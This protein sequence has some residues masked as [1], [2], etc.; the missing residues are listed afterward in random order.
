MK[1]VLLIISLLFFMQGCQKSPKPYPEIGLLPKEKMNSISLFKQDLFISDALYE[2]AIFEVR[3]EV[4]NRKIGEPKGT[5]MGSMYNYKRFKAP[6]IEY[7]FDKPYRVQRLYLND[8]SVE[9]MRM[10]FFRKFALYLGPI[11]GIK[12][13]RKK[14]ELVS[15]DL[16]DSAYDVLDSKMSKKFT[17]M[18][19]SVYKGTK[20][21]IRLE[22][23]DTNITAL[24]F[25]EKYL[26]DLI[27]EN[28]RERDDLILNEA[29]LQ[30]VARKYAEV[31]IRLHA[32]TAE[33]K[34]PKGSISV[35][36][37]DADMSTINMKDVYE[38]GRYKSKAGSYKVF[39]P[40]EPLEV[41]LSIEEYERHIIET[42]RTIRGIKEAKDIPDHDGFIDFSKEL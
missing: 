12:K 26:F 41:D 29:L 6:I 36:P 35:L 20:E 5:D 40:D 13:N 32:H 3:P 31:Y 34:L 8:P 38:K 1:Q 10:V 16:E 27:D 15:I 39:I 19:S 2:K 30:R 21:S 4:S 28:L 24:V 7:E 18:I 23:V 17:L 14:L 9:P 42:H 37:E 11:K 22:P 25:N 33:Y